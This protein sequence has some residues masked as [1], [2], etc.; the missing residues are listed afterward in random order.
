VNGAPFAIPH[1]ILWW[2]EIANFNQGGL[3]L[4]V[5]YCPLTGTAVAFDRAAVGGAEFGVSGLLFRNNLVMY[6]RNDEDTLWPQIMGEGV[7]GLRKR[8][9]LERLP[10][11][12]MTWGAWRELHPQ[13][14]VVSDDTGFSR[15]YDVYPYGDYEE[16]DQPPFLPQNYDRSRP[17]KERRLGREG[18]DGSAIAI[19]FGELDTAARTVHDLTLDG[20]LI[21]IVWD[22]D[23]F[24]AIAFNRRPVDEAGT[25]HDPVTL[26]VVSGDFVDA[27]TGSTWSLDGRAVSG[28]LAGLRLLLHPEAMIAFW[29][30]WGGFHPTTS[31]FLPTT[32]EDGSGAGGGP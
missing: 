4:A 22:R 23:A 25:P 2:H 24:T 21:T 15:D 17:P 27:E 19:A 16:L 3:S 26:E 1:N 31:V 14:T 18:A 13:T 32:G 12:E 10:V 8:D 29:F 7:C 6:D 30:A 9:E 28:P 5:T 20:E 11:L